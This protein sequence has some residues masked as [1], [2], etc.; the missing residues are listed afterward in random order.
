MIEQ[1]ISVQGVQDA[2]IS[3]V[4][5]QPSAAN[6]TDVMRFNM[7]LSQE[8]SSSVPKSDLL[9][10]VRVDT[11]RI[12]NDLLIMNNSTKDSTVSNP[13]ARLDGAY[14]DIMNQ[15]NDVPQFDKFHEITQSDKAPAVRTNVLE[16]EAPNP[17]EQVKQMLDEMREVR[18]TAGAF[19][20]DISKWHMT[21]QIWSANIKILTTVVS[22]ASQGF[23][24]LFRSAG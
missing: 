12:D 3:D 14:R 4:S 13:L 24:T 6:G 23:K 7:E 2:F 9:Q 21:T 18:V 22:Q 19:S 10:D 15:L 11:A 1:L 17:A 8:N 5:K 20:K 16:T